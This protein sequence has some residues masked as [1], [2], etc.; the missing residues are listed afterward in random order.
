MN[1]FKDEDESFKKIKE[2]MSNS[3]RMISK[4]DVADA[5]GSAV[6]SAMSAM[7][8]S[9]NVHRANVI[10]ALDTKNSLDNL[11]PEESHEK[12][13][14]EEAPDVEFEEKYDDL[15]CRLFTHAAN[16]F[17]SLQVKIKD[18]RI[19]ERRSAKYTEL[20]LLISEAGLI[21]EYYEWLRENGYNS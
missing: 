5:I 4:L 16:G 13:K 6:T 1:I 9:H 14:Y 3:K 7:V 18:Q 17:L 20:L 8:F 12:E 11:F 15:K 2:E 10:A 21:N 19:A